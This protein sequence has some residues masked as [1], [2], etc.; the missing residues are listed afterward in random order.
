M[1][2]ENKTQLEQLYT[3]LKLLARQEVIKELE[4]KFRK[5]GDVDSLTKLNQIAKQK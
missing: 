5:K 2:I 1:T 4:Q 3:G